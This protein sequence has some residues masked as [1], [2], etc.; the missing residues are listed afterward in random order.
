MKHSAMTEPL[1]NPSRIQAAKL[2][3]PVMRRVVPYIIIS[4]FYVNIQFCKFCI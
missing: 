1:R 4:I 3:S 2:N